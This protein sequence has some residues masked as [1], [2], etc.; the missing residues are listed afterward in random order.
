MSKVLGHNARLY[1]GADLVAHTSEVSINMDTDIEEV[2]DA[3]SG[4]WAENAPTLNRWNIDAT[5]W[6]HNA[7]AAGADFADVLAA[8]KAQTQLTLKVEL[9]TGVDM[10]G[11]GYLTNLNASGGTAAAHISFTA[12]FIGTGEL[13]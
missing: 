7:V 5:A 8:W 12:A 2:T 10:T 13:S 11:L 3:D 1:L 4:I 9:E 6:Y